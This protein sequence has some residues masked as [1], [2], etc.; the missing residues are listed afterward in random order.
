M[1]I[2]EIFHDAGT[3]QRHVASGA[4]ANR[5]LDD[6][7]RRHARERGDKLA[8]VDRRWRLSYAELDR[9]AHRVACG[10]LHL[11]V[12][13]GDVV[14]LQLP[15]WAE[16]LIVHC[17]ATRIGA[18]TNS[19]GAVYRAREVGYILG[20]AEA[21]VMVVPDTFRAFSYTAMLAELRP[22]LP[23]LRHVLVVGDRVPDGMQSFQRFLD[24]P[25]EDR[26]S[27]ADVAARRPDPNAVTT[28][29]F[30]SG[31]EANP[32]GVMQ[33]H[34]SLGA[35]TRQPAEALG[36]TAEDVVFMPSPIGH[37]TA[38]LLGARVP[39]MYGMT[40]VWQE[41]WNAEEAVELI[42]REGCTFTFS[43]TPFLHGL[44]HA[45]NATRDALR[46]FR[47]FGCG[48]A[49]IPR[50][51]I[52]RAEDVHGFR[53]AA[54]YGSSEALVNSATTPDVPREWRYR[55][56]GRILDGQ[57]ARVVDPETG[58]PRPAGEPGELQVRTPALFA[59]YHRDPARTREV[60][61]EDGWYS[62]GDLC[63]LEGRY[64]SVVGR[65]KDMIIRGGANISAREIEE[66]LFAH[67]KVTGVACVAMPDPVLAER[68]CAFVICAPGAPL[69]FDEMIAFLKDQRIAAWKLP[70]RLEIR[71]AF[72]MTASG[73]VQKYLLREEIARLVGQTLLVR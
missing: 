67:P 15:N 25:W 1:A 34:N 62:T 56:D 45:P 51:L 50:A 72:P 9:L 40:A 4:W 59:G 55:A 44:V 65:K 14:S 22:H 71:D 58:A 66:L 63:A 29:M 19:I 11:G 27:A 54:C 28:L 3:I 41:H 42:A 12:G 39:I 53:V 38:V 8:L 46:S 16:W 21:S 23:R 64:L 20:H 36:W 31:T 68:V 35:G 26:Y 32:K 7:L 73:K 30:T 37:I 47:L 6:D 10:L 48:G 24:T 5:T 57:D 18:V 69:T 49:P 17:A 60:V 52:R 2:P 70:E 43:A 33:T 13:E 61:S